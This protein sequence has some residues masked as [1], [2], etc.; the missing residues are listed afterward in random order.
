M[1]RLE[2]PPRQY[3][4]ELRLLGKLLHPDGI[5]DRWSRSV[6]LRGFRCSRNRDDIEIKVGCQ[7]LVETYFFTAEKVA[8]I[9]VRKIEKSKID[10]FF[11][12]ICEAAGQDDPGYMGLDDCDLFNRMM[13]PGGIFQCLDEWGKMAEGHGIPDGVV[14]NVFRVD[15]LRCN[16]KQSMV[17]IKEKVVR[18]VSGPRPSLVAE[19]QHEDNKFKMIRFR[20]SLTIIVWIWDIPASACSVT[21]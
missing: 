10:G 9:E 6:Q 17:L 1:F 11:D 7:P 13:V 14:G 2:V 5:L 4:I 19:S 18:G 15:C 16:V 12:L 3:A 20:R 8:T 21:R